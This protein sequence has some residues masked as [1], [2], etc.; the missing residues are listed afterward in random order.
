MRSMH[1][2]AMVVVVGRGI[3]ACGDAGAEP[4]ITGESEVRSEA[5]A[6]VLTEA[7]DGK[8]ITVGEGKDVV[9]E[10]ASHEALR[11]SG[12]AWRVVATDKSFG[13]PAAAEVVPTSDSTRALERFVWKTRGPLSLIG[14]H[15]VKMEL[16]GRAPEPVSTFSFTVKIVRSACPEL[17]PP[18]PSFCSG[19]T[20]GTRQN[21]S[22]C[23]VY[24][25]QY[26]ID[27]RD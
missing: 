23:T 27:G 21:A 3:L 2:F 12:Q 16:R 19:G 15:I 8:T 25:C 13:Y 9:V 11:G 24:T 14:D 20:V 4:P 17:M 6:D 5:N 22:G 7:D 18:G 26:G 1:W 10:L